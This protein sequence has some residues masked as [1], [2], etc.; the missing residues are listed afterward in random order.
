MNVVLGTFGCTL[1]W[2]L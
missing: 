1:P 2:P